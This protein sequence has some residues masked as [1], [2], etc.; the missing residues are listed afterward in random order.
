[1]TFNLEITISPKSV[2]QKMIECGIIDKADSKRI[3]DLLQSKNNTTIKLKGNKKIYNSREFRT[4]LIIAA[5][6]SNTF[7]KAA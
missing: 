4:S 5:T 1:M 3:I 2:V 6:I 7:K